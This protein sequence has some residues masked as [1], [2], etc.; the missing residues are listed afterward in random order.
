M[1]ERATE[2]LLRDLSHGLE[3]VRPIPRLRTQVL[4]LLALFAA[5]V[6]MHAL[7]GG[8]LPLRVAGVPWSDPVFAIVLVGLVLT[9][10]GAVVA[11]LCG[12]VPGREREARAGRAV[13]V[14]GALLASAGGLWGLTG[15]PLEAF[16]F[17][18]SAPCIGRAS[19]L[20]IVPALFLCVALIGAF[21]RRP[22]VGCAFASVGAVTLSA[23]LVHTTCPH[24][25][26]AHILLGHWAAP[27]TVALVLAL[28]LSLLVR[29]ATRRSA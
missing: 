12:A 15:A 2:S 20:A 4:R 1:S 27:F 29:A 13:A 18:D 8:P 25:G 21:E 6:G 16:P 17:R 14:C 7:L 26:A 9:A 24:G 19:V 11:A 23:V 3:P 10:A 5:V 28:P 22:L